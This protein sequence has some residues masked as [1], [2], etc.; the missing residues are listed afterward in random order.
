MG[1]KTKKAVS[2]SVDCYEYSN[3]QT[4]LWDWRTTDLVA[5]KIKAEEYAARGAFA[6]SGFTADGEEAEAWLLDHH[7]KWIKS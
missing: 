4:H 2:Y 5:A 1:S 3:A 7:G 6:V